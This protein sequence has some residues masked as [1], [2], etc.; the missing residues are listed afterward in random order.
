ML[1]SATVDIPDIK[2]PTLSI[3]TDAGIETISKINTLKYAN[4]PAVLIKAKI[5]RL[6]DISRR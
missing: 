2:P 1:N 6:K 4:S 5:K 3:L